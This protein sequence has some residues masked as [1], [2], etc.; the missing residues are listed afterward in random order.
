MSPHPE[1][2]LRRPRV[3]GQRAAGRRAAD[4][5]TAEKTTADGGTAAAPP[6][7]VN[8]PTVNPPTA[9]P[10]TANPPTVW[11][12]AAALPAPGRLKGADSPAAPD[13]RV[14]TRRRPW[15]RRR[16]PLAGRGR[17]RGGVGHW[18]LVSALVITV[19]L[20][21]AAGAFAWRD[22]QAAAVASARVESVAAARSAARDV[23][24]LDYRTLKADSRA[25][26][27]RLTPAFRRKYQQVLDG[28]VAKLAGENKGVLKA[29]V[30]AAG[31]RDATADSAVVLAFVDIAS[32]TAK[33][34]TVRT[35]ANRVRLQMK[36]IDGR[37]LVD[38]IQ[39][40]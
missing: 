37:W 16:V 35:D 11:P 4:G 18:L 28:L 1:D 10:P 3:A 30:V 36:R 21:A 2:R 40:I 27:A 22:R 12:E 29:T 7:T 25:A 19:A 31:V 38:N 14:R 9:N 6:P 20:A 33:R 17:R 39:G 13:T 23:F 26:A 8:P 34:P 32:T 24:S 15:R 5:G